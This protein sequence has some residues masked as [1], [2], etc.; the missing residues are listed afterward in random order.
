MTFRRSGARGALRRWREVAAGA[1]LA[2][3]GLWWANAMH[4]PVRWVALPILV[5]GAAILWTGLQRLRF[6]RGGGGA[7]V[8][9][10]VERRLAYWGPLTGGAVDIDDLD[11]LAFDPGHK[12]AHWVLTPSKGD[13]LFIPIDAEGADGL[14]DL[15][16]ALPGLRAERMLDLLA[17]P[18]D[19]PVTLW[20]A[21]Q[22]GQTGRLRLH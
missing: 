21:G 9:Q 5:T 2:C 17:H 22:T 19:R 20:Q 10:I 4:S 7:G 12:P 15:F 3:L 11:R 16:T 18:P 13:V 6:A 1:A 14:F 8:V